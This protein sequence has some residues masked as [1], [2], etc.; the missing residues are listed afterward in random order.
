MTP[1]CQYQMELL[2]GYYHTIKFSSRGARISG[3]VPGVGHQDLIFGYDLNFVCARDRVYLHVQYSIKSRDSGQALMYAGTTVHDLYNKPL[4]V[5]L[6]EA[7]H[8]PRLRKRLELMP[9]QVY[10]KSLQHLGQLMIAS[11]R[12]FNLENLQGLCRRLLHTRNVERVRLFDV[13]PGL[14]ASDIRTSPSLDPRQVYTRI[15]NG[16]IPLMVELHPD[17]LDIYLSPKIMRRRVV[18]QL[19]KDADILYAGVD[20]PY[21]EFPFTSIKLNKGLDRDAAYLHSFTRHPDT[22]E[23]AETLPLVYTFENVK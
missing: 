13:R 9:K 5:L 7:Y 2:A 20:V 17:Y 14:E 6:Y 11:Q 22:A 10:E 16:I 12:L 1:V 15:L 4:H 21:G 18:S 19:N 8:S 3:E 23:E